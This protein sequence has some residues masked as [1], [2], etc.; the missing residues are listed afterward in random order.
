MLSDEIPLTT[1]G[2]TWAADN[3][4]VF[5][6]RK[7]EQTLRSNQVYRH[8]LG[9]PV[10]DD[11][12]VF[13]EEDET[14]ACGVY[15]TKSDAFFGDLHL[16]NLVAGV[17]GVCVPTTPWGSGRSFSPASAILE[18]GIS[19]Y[20]DHFYI[21]TN[22]E[23]KNFRLMKTPVNATSK[24]NWEEV[25]PHRADVLLEGI[26]IFKDH[27]VI[28]ER[29][30]GLNQ[31]RIKRWDG[32]VDEYLEFNDPAYTAGTRSNPDFNTEILR[33]GYSSMTTT[34]QSTY[35]HNM[36]T[37]E[38]TLLKQ[39][40]VIDDNFSPDNYTSERLMVE[41]RDGVKVPVSMVYKKG[42][43]A[44]RRKPILALC[45]RQLW[46]QHGPLFFQ[47]FGFPCSTAVS[48]M[49]LRTFGGAREMGRQWYED[50]KLLKKTEY[51]QRL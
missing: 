23:A 4:T 46:G 29:K 40:E 3:K 36:R 51:V 13:E 10:A 14:F 19:H 16:T 6:T 5:Y 17:P 11:V 39:Q 7:D 28:E 15:R 12:L 38:R 35:D 2:A 49:P 27:L 34:E 37:G 47:A 25:I 31:I 21:V 42:S 33:F 24:E 41:V 43:R 8:V 18:Y 48:C 50:G 30:E 22:L 44:E 1:G 32:T 26:D 9:T 20:G 45:L